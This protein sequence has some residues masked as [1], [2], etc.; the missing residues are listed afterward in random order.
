MEALNV[1]SRSQ[2]QLNHMIKSF[3]MEWSFDRK[4][5]EWSE[6]IRRLQEDV[7]KFLQS[8]QRVED[9]SC[10]HDEFTWALS[11]VKLD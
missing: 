9:S 10:A 8:I 11:T 4:P 1:Q 7:D 2:S 3:E 6:S 5:I